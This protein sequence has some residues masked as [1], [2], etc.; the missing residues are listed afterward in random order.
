MN[1]NNVLNLF[2]TKEDV[3][4]IVNKDTIKKSPVNFSKDWVK[5]SKLRIS[6][7]IS[8]WR[9]AIQSAES[10]YN[11]NRYLLYTI[12]DEIILDS[13]IT[14]LM[15]TRKNK[16]LS[17][18]Y[19]LVD[20]NGIENFD[21]TKLFQKE[22]FSDFL[23]YALDGKIFYGHALIEIG[24]I[25]NGEISE[26]C[27]VDK[28]HVKPEFNI[29][30]NSPFDNN[31]IDYTASPYKDWIIEVGDRCELGILNKAVPLALWKRQGFSA[32]AEFCEVFGMPLRIGKTDIR[33]E[34]LRA[35]MSEMLKNMGS[36]SWALLDESESVEYI[37]RKNSDGSVY[38]G[39]IR[40]AN[41]E[42]A[43]LI[44]GVTMLS[45]SG[46][47]RS[48]A[49]VHENVAIEYSLSDMKLLEYLVNGK[50]IPLMINLG[51]DLNGYTFQFDYNEKIEIQDKI[52]AY[53]EVAK[54]NN[55]SSKWVLDNFGIEID[56]PKTITTKNNSSPL[57]FL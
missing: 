44:V 26:V 23:K 47:S 16:T 46:S 30:V 15:N 33:D 22:W 27:L 54:F 2:K 32:Y 29:V 21:K 19:K 8:K 5:L 34:E 1:L 50:L 25:I 31:G 39:L 51:I 7:D 28:F 42:I 40:L 10:Q 17:K 55:V 3:K 35:N 36:S 13:Q 6:Q 43:K 57:N 49:S 53:A 38:D 41:E 9:T 4:E 12:Y 52:S 20:T 56:S 11:P 37:E 45:D 48:Q 24:D 14:S 18:N